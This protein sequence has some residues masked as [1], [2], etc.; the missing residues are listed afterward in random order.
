[1]KSLFAQKIYSSPSEIMLTFPFDAGSK[2]RSTGSRA[3]LRDCGVEL[4]RGSFEIL[5]N[6]T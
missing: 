6:G 1:M 2:V 4:L 5:G 3:S